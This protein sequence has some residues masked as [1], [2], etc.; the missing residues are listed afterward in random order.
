[1]P[2]RFFPVSWYAEKIVD[3]FVVRDA[4]GQ[5]IV[6]LYSRATEAEARQAKVLTD[7][8][9]RRIALNITK[10]PAILQREDDCTISKRLSGNQD[11]AQRQLL[12][13][14]QR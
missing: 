4:K 5:A 9:A 11:T 12:R 7:D 3:G 13:P 10:L 14:R 6:Y 8:E 1:M 2:N